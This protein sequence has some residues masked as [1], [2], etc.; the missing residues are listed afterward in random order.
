MVLGSTVVAV[1]S[2]AILKNHLV[3][4]RHGVVIVSEINIL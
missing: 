2:L 4:I 1:N 3:K